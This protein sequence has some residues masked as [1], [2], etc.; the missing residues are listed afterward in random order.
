MRGTLVRVVNEDVRDLL[1][2]IAAPTLLIW[3]ELDDSTP[4][5]DGQIMEA[6][7]PDAG[8]VVFPSAGHFAYADDYDRF[9]RVAS[10][11][12]SHQSSAVSRQSSTTPP[13]TDD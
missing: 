12:L 2:R 13:T 10:N 8:L 5:A 7:I 6:L 11:F 4:L 1:P 9:A 3:G